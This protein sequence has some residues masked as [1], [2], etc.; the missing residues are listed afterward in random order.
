MPICLRSAFA[1]PKA[2]IG[3]SRDRGGRRR[4]AP[5]VVVSTATLRAGSSGG[6]PSRPGSASRSARTRS[7]PSRPSADS[8][9][10]TCTGSGRRSAHL[11]SVPRGERAASTCRRRNHALRIAGAH[12]QRPARVAA[13]DSAAGRC[14][15]RPAG[16]GSEPFVG[17]GKVHPHRHRGVHTAPSVSVTR[18]LT[19]PA[20][21]ILP[22]RSPPASCL[23]RP[24]RRDA[25][26]P[27]E[28][29]E[30][31]DSRGEGPQPRLARRSSSASALSRSMVSN[32]I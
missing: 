22:P 9:Q 26:P 32:W 24:N 25:R 28:G 12:G 16:E 15:S 3:P 1:D 21:T 23:R 14:Y 2:K 27:G 11:S 7:N 13:I 19:T 18:R 30:C 5:M 4:A 10:Q 6:S 8:A 20:G 31:T 29:H 17:D